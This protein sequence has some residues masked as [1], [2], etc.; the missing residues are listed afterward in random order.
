MLMIAKTKFNMKLLVWT[1]QSD[2]RSSVLRF[3]PGKPLASRLKCWTNPSQHNFFQTVSYILCDGQL[4]DTWTWETCDQ[5]H[6]TNK[7]NEQTITS[8]EILWWDF[9]TTFQ[10]MPLQ[11]DFE[12]TN[13]PRNGDTWV[14]DKLKCLT[15]IFSAHQAHVAVVSTQFFT[16]NIFPT[17]SPK[18]P[19]AG[20]AHKS[21]RDHTWTKEESN[22]SSNCAMQLD[23]WLISSRVWSLLISDHPIWKSKWLTI[24]KTVWLILQLFWLEIHQTDLSQL[25]DSSNRTACFPPFSHSSNFKSSISSQTAWSEGPARGLSMNWT[26]IWIWLSMNEWQWYHQI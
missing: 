16:Y 12:L 2:S 25:D 23:L 20:V 13:I 19:A 14:S 10:E 21:I 15:I 4:S 6:K 9:E 8:Q 3:R 22:K 24:K 18:F 5:H 11:W 17:L 7:V 26:D 1:S